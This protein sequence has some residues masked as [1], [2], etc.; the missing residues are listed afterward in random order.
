MRSLKR[1]LV[2]VLAASL[3]SLGLVLDPMGQK[4]AHAAD[5]YFGDDYTSYAAYGPPH[6]DTP[7]PEPSWRSCRWRPARATGRRCRS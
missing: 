2:G 1:L 7:A 4:P 3:A 5:L 6:P